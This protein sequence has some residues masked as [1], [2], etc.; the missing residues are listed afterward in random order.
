MLCDRRNNDS[1]K[2]NQLGFFCCLPFLCQSEF[3]LFVIHTPWLQRGWLSVV[4]SAT[5]PTNKPYQTHF[6]RAIVCR[7]VRPSIRFIDM[8]NICPDKCLLCNFCFDFGFAGFPNTWQFNSALLYSALLTSKSNPTK[9]DTMD[10]TTTNK[11]QLKI[12]L[13]GGLPKKW[14][15]QRTRFGRIV[16]IDSIKYSLWALGHF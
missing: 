5:I 15:K 11:L 14:T 4:R 13:K 2:S 9:S 8:A 7:F 12:E 16:V 10:T 3:V 6:I 1:H